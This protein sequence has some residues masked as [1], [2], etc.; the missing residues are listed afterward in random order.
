MSASD[1]GRVFIYDDSG[2][3]TSVLQN[4]FSFGAY[5]TFLTDNAFR[6]LQYAGEIKPDI[7]ILNTKGKAPDVLQIPP[8]S[9]P[10]VLTGRPARGFEAYPQ[11]AHYVSLPFEMKKL[12]DIAESYCFGNKRHRI[13]LLDTY[14]P[15]YDRLHKS[16]DT[17]SLSYFEVHNEQAAS[18]YL[19]KNTPDIVLVEYTPK[20]VVARHNLHHDKIFYVDRHQ[21]IAEIEKFLY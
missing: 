9:C 13:M 17:S 1:F 6:F 4:I 3:K 16:L 7:M 21:D 2:Q 15:H 20:L 10:V 11:V 14:S 12:N 19:S 5:K 18:I 8:A